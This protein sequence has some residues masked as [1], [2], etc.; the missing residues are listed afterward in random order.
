MPQWL[1]SRLSSIA[2]IPLQIMELFGSFSLFSIRERKLQSLVA[3]C[4]DW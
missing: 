3:S 4:D 2:A 1:G